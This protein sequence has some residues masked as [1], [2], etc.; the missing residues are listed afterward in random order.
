MEVIDSAMAVWR[1]NPKRVTIQQ[2]EGFVRQILGWREYMRGVYWALM[3]GLAQ[4]NFF[5]HDR[6]LPD[7]YWTAATRMQCLR[8]AIGQS[9]THAP[10]S[11]RT[12]ESA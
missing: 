4:M 3:P 1:E 12:R 10:S 2:V 8:A 9:L 5:G 11:N 6:P 7:F